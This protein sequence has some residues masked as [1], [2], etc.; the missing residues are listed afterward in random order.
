MSKKTV[1]KIIET[2]ND[3]LIKVKKNQPKLY[4]Q[5]EQQVKSTQVVKRYVDE[6]KTRDRYTTRIVEVFNIPANILD[7]WKGAGSVI[8]VKRSSNRGSKLVESISYY[9][10]SLSPKSTTL[11]SGIRGHWLIENQLPYRKGCDS[12]GRFKSSKIRVFC[13]QFLNF[14]NLGI[15]STK[16]TWFCR[17]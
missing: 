6:E 1:A 7:V 3:Y 14:K 13:R 12:R 16:N 17:N 8:R 11:A 9:L 2:Q 10:C 4:E 15:N 5:I